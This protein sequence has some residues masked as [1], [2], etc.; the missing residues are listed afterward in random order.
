MQISALNENTLEKEKARLIKVDPFLII[1][2]IKSSI[3]ILMN[4]KIEEHDESD[5]E[6]PKKKK[7][8]ATHRSSMVS[9]GSTE[10]LEDPPKDY[11]IMI[12]KLE[13]EVRSHIRV[14]FY[15]YH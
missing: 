12:Q 4:L 13:A 6:H 10:S 3:E 1:E 11:E 2:Y 5:E 9:V 15:H 7:K 14:I 8:S